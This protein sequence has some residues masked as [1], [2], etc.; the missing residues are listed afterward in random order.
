MNEYTIELWGF[1]PLNGEDEFL[2]ETSVDAETDQ[3]ALDTAAE[4]FLEFH[5]HFDE[6]FIRTNMRISEVK[7]ISAEDEKQIR[8][9]M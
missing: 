7:K 8:G 1:H 3:E 4:L 5:P 9:E 2:D 6:D